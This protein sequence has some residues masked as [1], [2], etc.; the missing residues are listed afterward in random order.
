MQALQFRR[1]LER[2]VVGWELG[3]IRGCGK[4]A[5]GGEVFDWCDRL[6]E[7]CAELLRG[8]MRQCFETGQNDAGFD[9]MLKAGDGVIADATGDDQIEVAQVGGDVEGEAVGGD[10]AG[11][12]NTNGGDFAL[13]VGGSIGS[14]SRLGQRADL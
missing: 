11:D 2:N 13:Q 10:A 14:C 12:V 1:Y 9:F 5:E 4:G 3:R 8:L 6:V 7:D